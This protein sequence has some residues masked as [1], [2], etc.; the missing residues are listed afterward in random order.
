MAETVTGTGEIDRTAG[1]I[2]ALE[3]Y[4]SKGTYEADRYPAAIDLDEGEKARS[5]LRIFRFYEALPPPPAGKPG[6]E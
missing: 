2:K 4:A 3:F 6:G 5:A 1:L